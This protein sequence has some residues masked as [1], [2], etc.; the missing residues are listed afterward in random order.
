[1]RLIKVNFLKKI[2]KNSYH[3]FISKFRN[4]DVDYFIKFELNEYVFPVN[5]NEFHLQKCIGHLK[6]SY[7]S[8]G[9]KGFASKF[10]YKRN[11]FGPLYPEVTGYIINTLYEIKGNF[12]S[13]KDISWIDNAI[14]NSVKSLMAVQLENGGF[15]AGHKDMHS[16]GT[17]SIFNT[18]QILLGLS[19]YL[20][21]TGDKFVEESIS[22]AVNFMNLNSGLDGY[23][24]EY[25]YNKKFSSYYAR[26]AYGHIKAGKLIGDEKSKDK[27][28]NVL[29]KIL[30]YAD[31]EGSISGWGFKQN[32]HALHTV[33]YTLRGFFEVGKELED[34]KFLNT[35]WQG[36]KW[37]ENR[38]P[39]IKINGKEISNGDYI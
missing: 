29:K 21:I 33:I 5:R 37:L 30:S 17:P 28:S 34:A 10:D 20:S 16:Y 3:Y 4:K 6:T 38:G 12:N 39:R 22:R 8:T 15:T 32:W 35:S 9:K 19:Q 26:S 18:G 14:E 23:N 27:V 24:P 7:L 13:S 31:Q 11:T 2:I 36:I 1:M 25:C